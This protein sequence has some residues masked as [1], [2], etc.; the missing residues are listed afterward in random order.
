[1][2]VLAAIP[3]S[4]GGG[5]QLEVVNDHQTQVIDA[6]ALGVH[7]RHRQQGIIVDA[8]IQTAQGGGALG[9]LH[10]VALPQV[11][12]DEAG[13][14]DETLA[15]QQTG[16]Q[17]VT[18]HLQRKDG[19]RLAGLLGG[20]QGHVQSHTGLAHAGTGGQQQQIRLVQAVDLAVHRRKAGGQTRQGLAPLSAEL[21]QM[22]HD[23]LQHHLNGG[24][25]LGAAAPADGVDLLLRRLQHVAGGAGPL[26][27]HGGDLRRR[28]GHRPQQGLLTHQT[29]ILQHIGGSGRHLHQLGQ[30]RPCAIVGEARLLQ[31]PGHGKSVDG[32]GVN[33]HGVDG[34]ENFPV[35]A[36]VEIVRLKLVHHVLDAGGVNEHGAQHGL[37]RFCGVRHLPQKQFIHEGT[38]F[39]D[40]SE[41]G[42][43]C[44]SFCLRRFTFPSSWKSGQKHTP[45]CQPVSSHIVAWK[46]GHFLETASLHPPPA[47]LR[48]FFRND[49]SYY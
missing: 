24:H 12:A 39:G 3:L 4:A 18:G 23:L 38:P 26:L 21:R 17:L 42:G 9:D 36:E 48:R 35:L 45:S 31:L 5:H 27:H 40:F 25:A 37:L 14:F 6:A 7:V 10:P 30:I 1:M 29:H 41:G 33:E 47:A 34:L 19:H 32:A 43:V 44:F 28:C 2:A 22:L 49:R 15:G 16:H 11:A 20:V 8:D 46:P 13:I